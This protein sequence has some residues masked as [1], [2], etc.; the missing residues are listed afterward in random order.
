MT[1]G[2]PRINLTCSFDMPGF[3]CATISCDMKL[4]CWITI[5]YGVTPGI[6]GTSTDLQAGSSAAASSAGI[7]AQTRRR[8]IFMSL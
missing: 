3:S 4:P 2:V 8:F 6:L 5:R 1:S 7:P